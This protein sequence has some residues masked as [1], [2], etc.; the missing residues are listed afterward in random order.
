MIFDGDQIR[1]QKHMVELLEEILHLLRHRLPHHHFPTH[2]IVKETSMQQPDPGAT[3]QFTATPQP[4]GSSLG[5]VVPT[6]TSSDPN[7][8]LT[9]DSTGL[10][11]T[12]VLSASITVGASVTLTISAQD[13]SDSTKAPA[14]GSV[15]FTVGQAPPPPPTFPTSF[16]VTQTA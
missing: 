12:A 8:S 7:V 2:F 10:V 4:D 3:L 11:V 9:A 16:S 5:G 15:T 14:T 1:L 6:W 13:P